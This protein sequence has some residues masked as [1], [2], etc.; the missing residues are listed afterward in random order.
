MRLGRLD[1]SFRAAILTFSRLS[2]MSSPSLSDTPDAIAASPLD[3][4]ATTA[5]SRRSRRNWLVMWSMNAIGVLAL[6]ALLTLVT[7]NSVL[8]FI[9][10]GYTIFAAGRVART[11]HIRDGAPGLGVMKRSVGLLLAATPWLV[12][13]YVIHR[14]A[15]DSYWIDPVSLSRRVALY[16]AWGI[17]L[18]VFAHLGIGLMRGTVA[19]HI[20]Q[21]LRNLGWLVG[22]IADG[23]LPRLL[24]AQIVLAGETFRLPGLFWLG[25]Y[26]FA[27]TWLWLAAPAWLLS[28]GTIEPWQ[29]WMGGALLVVVACHLPIMQTRFSMQGSW[30]AMFDVA[31]AWRSFAAA[32]HRWLLAGT[33]FLLLALPLYALKG[34]RFSADLMWALSG[35]VVI[36]TF[37]TRLI[38][39]WAQAGCLANQ[40]RSSRWLVSSCGALL[41]VTA[42]AYTVL[43]YY[44]QYFDWHGAVGLWKQHA[45]LLPNLY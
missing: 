39:G 45:F 11:G 31:G 15:G 26:C 35:I 28:H 10:F 8:Q 42:T 29:A 20:Y 41:L 24:Y 21:P 4:T 43:V 23:T 7:G 14:L 12:F 36:V 3:D 18:L 1:Q 38:A 37:V 9:G 30:I 25:G 27:T 13:A 5:A 32:P 2:T 33:V 19:R 6:L 44:L 40:R 22:R 17:V 34:Y 16:G